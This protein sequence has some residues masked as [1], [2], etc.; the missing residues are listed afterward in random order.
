MK[1]LKIAIAVGSILWSLPLMAQKLE[2]RDFKETGEMTARLHGTAMT[3]ENS[4]KRAALIKIYTPFQNDVL[5]FDAG[6]F[7]IVGRKQAGPGEVWLYVPERTQKVTVTHPKYSPTIIV[8]E[9][10]EAEAGKT[11]SV[12]LDVE[13]RNVALIA[14][15]NKAPIIVDGDSVGISPV[16]VHLSYG[17]HHVTSELGNMVYDGNISVSKDGPSSF[18]LKMEDENDKYGQVSVTVP[19]K[20][21][22]WFEGHR[23]ALGEWHTRLKE[24][25]YSV[26]FRKKNCES[27]IESFNVKPRQAIDLKAKALIPF[28]GYLSVEL[29]P[30][31]GTNIYHADTLVA[32]NRLNRQLNIGDYT[33]TFKRKGYVTQ[34][35]TFSVR[36]NEETLDTV[37]L[38]RIQYIKNN[39]LYAGIGFTYGKISGVSVNIGG[40][41]KKIS[42]ELGYTLGLTRS[43]KV[44]WFQN[45]TDMFVGTTD[46]TVDELSGKL[47]YQFSFVQRIGLTPQLG[48][49]GQRVRGG[50]HGN[51]AM[52]H[53]LSI[54]A[55]FIFNPIS[56]LGIF[57]T[58]EFAIPVNVNPLY[59]EIASHAGLSKGGFF[60][61]AGIAFTF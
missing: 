8:I 42:A 15:V 33:Y 1:S 18:E 27:R 46:Y 30:T 45:S 51:G 4:G 56:Y 57:V 22:I 34:T 20:A 39:A 6:L 61:T 11:Y 2:C 21:E 55:R 32:E 52:S 40:V 28:R 24:G 14:S 41:F 59:D 17:E 7:K 12:E 31:V 37:R 23:V 58:P 44:F 3:D 49:L 48:Y 19:D 50:S 9:G 5:G 35:K 36:H 47:G 26:E 43:G 60:A 54:G 16:N 13:G 53:N 10:G 25:S 29:R 38:E